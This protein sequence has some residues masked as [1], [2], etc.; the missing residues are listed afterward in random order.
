[1]TRPKDGNKKAPRFRSCLDKEPEGPKTQKKC[2][3]DGAVSKE[4]LLLQFKNFND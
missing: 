1:M 4:K 3:K 2:A